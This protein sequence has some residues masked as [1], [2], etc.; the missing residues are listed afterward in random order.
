MIPLSIVID[1][2]PNLFRIGPFLITWHG[3]FAVLGILAGA[4]LGLW[5]LGKDGVEVKQG[6]D[7]V[8]WM[9]LVGLVG[10][11]LLYVWENYK[12]FAG[13]FARI[14]AVTEGGISQWGGLFG[15]MVGAYIWARR[16]AFSYWK[17]LDAAGAAA[18]I[19]LAIG[20]IGDVINGEHHGTPTTLPWGVEYVNPDTLGQPG[21][22]VH[23]EVAYEMILTLVLLG[24]I[25]PF[26]QRLKARLPDG[27]L[28]LAY[29]GL[30]AIGRFFL[31]YFRTDP[32]V[33]AGLRQAQLASL[34]M[35]AIAVVAIPI[36]FRRERS[37]AEPPS[38]PVE[39]SAIE[40][41]AELEPASAEAV[42]PAVP[43]P[44]E[45]PVVVEPDEVK[46]VEPDQ[47]VP[48][49]TQPEPDEPLPPTPKLPRKPRTRRP[50]APDP[51]PGTP[52]DLAT[53]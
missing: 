42:A 47:A 36:L 53:R 19:G 45:V 17:L 6:A 27:V 16:A 38:V 32:A 1:L 21:Q 22:I 9:V 14:F 5:L 31:S 23:P 34:L 50:K 28:G 12:L 4:R 7:G 44:V 10:A 26:H 37:A 46:A 11:R 40:P 51:G 52:T 3:V 35:V 15:A 18:M 29:L 43:E 2:E 13:N 8:A 24:A 20:R 30:Y 25:L 49:A 33:F 41:D 39:P 48:D